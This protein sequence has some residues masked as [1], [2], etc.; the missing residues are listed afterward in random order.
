M[1]FY[2]RLNIGDGDRLLRNAD[3]KRPI[4]LLPCKSLCALLVHPFRRGTLQ[5]LYCL[6]Q[7]DGRWERKEYVSVVY[8]PANY[9]SFESVFP[10]NP[11]QKCPQLW[12]NFRGDEFVTSL[13][14]KDAMYEAGDV[15]VRQR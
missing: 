1:M 7:W 13:G 8:R 5:Q 14:R 2:L 6:G 10:G 12:L 3:G 4:S 11:T 9:E 15:G